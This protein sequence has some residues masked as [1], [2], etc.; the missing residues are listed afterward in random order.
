MLAWGLALYG[1]ALLAKLHRLQ[2]W[3]TG[4]IGSA[5]NVSFL[6]GAGLLA[7]VGPAIARLGARTVLSGGA[8]LRPYCGHMDA[9]LKIS[10]NPSGLNPANRLRFA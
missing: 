3:S 10:A 2:G 5:T 1:Q 4:A 9:E 7:W 8:I 6:L